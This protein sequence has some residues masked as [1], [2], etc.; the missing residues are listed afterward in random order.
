MQAQCASRVPPRV[1]VRE[2]L[3]NQGRFVYENGLAIVPATIEDVC[4]RDSDRVGSSYT[5]SLLGAGTNGPE[6]G[7]ETGV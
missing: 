6:N 3:C 4:R 1:A 2:A 5:G 7:G